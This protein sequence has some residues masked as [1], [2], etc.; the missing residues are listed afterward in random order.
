MERFHKTWG[1][2]WLL[3]ANDTAEVSLLDLEPQRRCS[4]HKHQAKYN[5]FFVVSGK[6]HI[7]TENGLAHVHEGQVFT[8]RPGEFHEFQTTDEAATM[9]EVMYVK[10]DPEDIQR[11]SL[12]GPVGVAEVDI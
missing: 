9:I 12:G 6:V 8:T 4:W 11:E 7:K 2:R 1:E 10:Y 5:L 3:W